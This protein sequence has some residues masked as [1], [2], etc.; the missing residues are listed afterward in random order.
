MRRRRMDV[1][2]QIFSWKIQFSVSPSLFLSLAV[3][4]FYVCVPQTIIRENVYWRIFLS[5]HCLLPP[6]PPYILNTV[7]V[8]SDWM[9]CTVCLLLMLVKLCGIFSFLFGTY[10][11]CD[12]NIFDGCRSYRDKC[13]VIMFSIWQQSHRSDTAHDRL[14]RTW[15]DLSIRHFDSHRNTIRFPLIDG[16]E[17]IYYHFSWNVRTPNSISPLSMCLNSVSHR[18]PI[19]YPLLHTVSYQTSRT[20]QNE[21]KMENGDVREQKTKNCDAKT[22]GTSWK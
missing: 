15:K 7:Y 20:K 11:C 18:C 12:V 14:F 19:D 2:E 10:E 17:R 21:K 6:P 5:C 13:F 4:C 22:C 16:I 8:C 3:F 9:L 1:V